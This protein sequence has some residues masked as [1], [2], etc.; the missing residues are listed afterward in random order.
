MGVGGIVIKI[1]YVG[2]WIKI[3]E[4]IKNIDFGLLNLIIYLF[5]SLNEWIFD[6]IE[7]EELKLL[8]VVSIYVEIFD[9]LGVFVYKIVNICLFFF[10]FGIFCF[11][12]GENYLLIV[13][14]IE[15]YIKVV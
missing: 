11:Y 10:E 8:I 1:I 12:D 6:L 5:R 3:F 2:K 14:I 7:Y 13:S 4:F 9:M 15:N